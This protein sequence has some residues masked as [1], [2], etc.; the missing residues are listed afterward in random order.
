M[1][2]SALIPVLYLI[3]KFPTKNDEYQSIPLFPGEWTVGRDSVTDIPLPVETVSRV[4]ARLI[5]DAK[6]ITVL[7]M[8]STNGITIGLEKIIERRV[9][10]GSEIL[11]G[12]YPL[13]L[14]TTPKLPA[15]SGSLTKKVKQNLVPPRHP[16]RPAQSRVLVLLLH[17]DAFTEKEIAAKLHRSP[18]TVHNHVQ[19]IFEAYEVS[20][21]TELLMKVFGIG[22]DEEGIDR[23]S[24]GADS[25]GL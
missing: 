24:T 23:Y 5:V 11:F 18:D 15:N 13:L 14:S 25:T 6:G 3:P 8:G 17:K 9:L 12:E 2:T 7:D 19:R 21:R 20:S 1:T 4:H 22:Y 16:L 10:P